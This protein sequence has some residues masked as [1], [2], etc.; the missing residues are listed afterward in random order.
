MARFSEYIDAS[1]LPGEVYTAGLSDY[2]DR[3]QEIVDDLVAK[4]FKFAPGDDGDYFQQFLALQNNP[5]ALAESK[6]K[7]PRRFQEFMAMSGLGT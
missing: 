5:N 7:V 2:R 1:Y 4:K 6:M 3:P